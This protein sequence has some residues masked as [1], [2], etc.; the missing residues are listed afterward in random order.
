VAAIQQRIAQHSQPDIFRRKKIDLISVG[1]P[2]LMAQMQSFQLKIYLH[3]LI[4]RQNR[5]FIN[6]VGKWLSLVVWIF[7]SMYT[8]VKM[9][10]NG[11]KKNVLI[12]FVD[13]HWR[14]PNVKYVLIAIFDKVLLTT[15]D[16]GNS[17]PVFVYT[18]YKLNLYRTRS[19]HRRPLILRS[20]I[21]F[22]SLYICTPQNLQ[23]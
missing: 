4:R 19:F 5:F 3:T 22:Q 10:S 12:V 17:L 15:V 9:P 1:T 18:R 6:Y 16:S 2:F 11:K 13:W 21:M 20:K 8:H 7:S 23:L 14:Y